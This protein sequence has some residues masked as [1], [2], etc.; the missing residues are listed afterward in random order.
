[1]SWKDINKKSL[2]EIQMLAVIGITNV[3]RNSTQTE[4]IDLFIKALTAKR[5]IIP[6]TR[7]FGKNSHAVMQENYWKYN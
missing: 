3:M 5:A 4:A 7:A 6:K 1:M 2:T